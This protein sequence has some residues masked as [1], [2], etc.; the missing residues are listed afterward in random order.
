MKPWSCFNLYRA[1]R[2]LEQFYR[3]SG[4]VLTQ[5]LA[6]AGTHHHLV[7]KGYPLCAQS[8]HDGG[9]TIYRQ[10]DPV[11]ATGHRHCAIWHRAGRRRRGPS[12]PQI[13][14]IVV[15]DR[16]SR[17]ELLLHDETQ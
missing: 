12:Q 7:A 6:A 5:D 11:P 4:G 3:I 10:D 14:A 15:Q 1:L 8:R 17:A 2:W 16:H 13:E 9:Q